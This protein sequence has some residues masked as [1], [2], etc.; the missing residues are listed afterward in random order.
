MST[1]VY[2]MSC[3]VYISPQFTTICRFPAVG[4]GTLDALA[5]GI[6]SAIMKRQVI[7]AIEKLEGIQ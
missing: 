6:N 1:M 3:I 5:N 7:R 4:A 2:L